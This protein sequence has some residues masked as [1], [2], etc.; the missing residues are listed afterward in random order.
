[1]GVRHEKIK[2]PLNILYQN[3]QCI[4][5]KL[6]QFEIL[7]DSYQL[8]V[9]CLNEHWLKEEEMLGLQMSGFKLMSYYCRSTYKHGG[10][11]ILVKEHVSCKEIENIKTMEKTRYVKLPA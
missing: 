9:I 8:S 2:E 10:C 4:S 11:A 6:L 7:I 1:M 5:N 3:T